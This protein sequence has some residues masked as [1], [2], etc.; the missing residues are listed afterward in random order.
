M[1]QAAL[2]RAQACCRFGAAARSP[3]VTGTPEERPRASTLCQSFA[4][5]PR[6]FQWHAL[7]GG[8]P[9]ARAS[10]ACPPKAWITSLWVSMPFMGA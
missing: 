10:A 8:T 1:H 7:V 4:G 3:H 5:M 6:S 9:R 2:S